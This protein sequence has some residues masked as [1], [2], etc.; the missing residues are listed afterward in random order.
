MCPD[1]KTKI[2]V[3]PWVVL[4][5]ASFV[6][7][8]SPL[9]LSAVL[10][11]A[12]VHELGHYAL[13]RCL[14]GEIECIRISPFGADMRIRNRERLSYAGEMLAVAAGPTVNI[15]SA[16]LVAA[17]GK[18][19][20]VA[21]VFA[22]AQLVLGLF[23]LLPV[24]PLDGGTL[25]WLLAAWLADPFVADRVCRKIGLITLLLLL[26][27]GYLLLHH[28]SGSPFLL[29]GAAGIVGSCLPQLGLVNKRKRR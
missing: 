18:W 16:F 10:L 20:D 8:S 9:V 21:Y 26:L 23:N 2:F 5:L 22:G 12:L 14:G 11:A 3:S 28:E 4:L 13:L 19:A 29:I 25:V 6:L 27:G 7:L 24:L 17:A 1:K 15:L